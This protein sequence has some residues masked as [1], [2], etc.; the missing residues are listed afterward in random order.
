MNY[1]KKIHRKLSSV[2]S[3]INGIRYLTDKSSHK[4]IR[5]FWLI[6][7][8]LSIIGFSFYVYGV[9]SKWMLTPDIG[10]MVNLKPIRKV[11]FPAVTICAPMSIRNF[12]ANFNKVYHDLSFNKLRNPQEI[13]IAQQKMISAIVQAC[14]PNLSILFSQKIKH[15]VSDDLV[16]HLIRGSFT[17]NETLYRC[18]LD[19]DLKRNCSEMFN[20]IITD[21]GICYSYNMQGYNTIFNKNSVD[22]DFEL[23]IRMGIRNVAK[24][25]S[26][27]FDD[28][29]EDVE[30]TLQQGY[31]SNEDIVFPFRIISENSIEF[32]LM[33]PK[34]ET[35]NY[36]PSM[37]NSYKIIF[38]M[39]N[40]VPTKFH[41][42]IYSA[43]GTQ[44]L[45]SMTAKYFTTDSTMRKYKP[46]IRG[47]FF[48]NE[49]KLKFFK[50]YTKAHCDMEC[51][52][53]HTLR[54]CGCVKFSMPRSADTPVCNLEEAA[55]YN[56]A[57][58]HW[59]HNDEMSSNFAVP[60]NCFP[61]CNNIQYKTKLIDH[62]NIES[63]VNIANF[64]DIQNHS[65]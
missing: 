48:E 7:F 24:D 14:E 58:R 21:D 46:E 25:H 5:I 32:I 22:R 10:I 41:D 29:N 59:P 31:N 38:H 33:H 3:S 37:R 39:P 27:Y 61:P 51:L 42:Y 15:S 4:S 13:D 54:I 8:V 40:E 56:D 19:S 44:F 45:I 6:I 12:H 2:E 50:S 63:L 43:M 55:C 23:F 49:R 65:K 17:T 34:S 16:D 28:N 47:C 35:N 9:Y 62:V 11:P 20:R 52:T 1:D 18:Y 36:C 57:I 26:M 60:C 53:N 64:D 30:W